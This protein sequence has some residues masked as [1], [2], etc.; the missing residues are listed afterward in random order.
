M[1]FRESLMDHCHSREGPGK[2]W[3]QKGP[4]M[5]WE[6]PGMGWEKLADFSSEFFFLD[7]QKSS[8]NFDPK[9][10]P[11]RPGLRTKSRPIPEIVSCCY[12]KEKLMEIGFQA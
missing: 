3:G 5:G 4:G 11:T 1:G 8:K 6:R 12:I 7:G 2:M 10:S 9:S